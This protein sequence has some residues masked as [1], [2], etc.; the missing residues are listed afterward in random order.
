MAT[1]GQLRK[2]DPAW[3]PANVARFLGEPDE[4]APNPRYKR[5]AP[6]RLYKI[7]RAMA[8]EATPEFADAR[9]K[10]LRRSRSSLAAADA[11][12][13]ETLKWARG[14]EI[15]IGF[16]GTA[17][18]ARRLGYDHKLRLDADRA[19]E[20]HELPPDHDRYEDVPAPTLNRWAVNW[21]RHHRTSYERRLAQTFG[22]IGTDEA[23]HVVRR[24][25]L[26]AIRTRWP[27]LWPHDDPDTWWQRETAAVLGD[28]RLRRGKTPACEVFKLTRGGVTLA[29]YTH[30][31]SA[32]REGR[33]AARRIGCGFVDEAEERQA[34]FLFE[35]PPAGRLRIRGR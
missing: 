14:V 1:Q 7:G 10:A 6:M 28:V 15:K 35:E 26:D 20:R 33:L 17:E 31:A 32:V 21:L 9:V 16:D 3:T 34:A 12:R 13:S 5:A 19:A 25:V 22:K 24:R 8:V 11:K 29:T 2:R 18:E 27:G 4:L 30:H 23:Y